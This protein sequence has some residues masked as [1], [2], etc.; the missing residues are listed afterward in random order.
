VISQ[1]ITVTPR[2]Q[3]LVNAGDGPC[4]VFNNDLLN[5]IYVG[6]DIGITATQPNVAQIAPLAYVAFD[7]RD[8]KWFCTGTG[9]TAQASVMPG[10]LTTSASPA[11]IA[12]QIA[13]SGVPLLPQ[14]TLLGSIDSLLTVVPGNTTLY[15]GPVPGISYAISID[16]LNNG[17]PT[18]PFMK[19]SLIWKNGP[20]G[21]TL[22]IQQW[23]ILTTNVS[24][25]SS[26]TLVVGRGPT[27][28]AQLTVIVDNYDV[29]N[30]TLDFGLWSSSRIITRHDFRSI[31]NNISGSYTY[32]PASIGLPAWPTPVSANGINLLGTAPNLSIGAASSL[33]RINGLYAG[34]AQLNVS[35]TS[36]AVYTILVTLFAADPD[37]T[38]GSPSQWTQVYAGQFAGGAGITGFLDALNLTLPR[39]P[40]L[41]WL[42]NQ[43]TAGFTGKYSLVSQEFAS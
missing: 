22:A 31:S 17:A 14:D 32:D 43:G 9:L 30:I 25:A 18:T 12:E 6:E 42:Q 15:S 35:G 37:L 10:A 28:S 21:S 2:A 11:L 41:L 33:A 36:L 40:T 5:T 4:L 26:N 39:A 24:P 19:L 3:V 8:T 29:N 13:L 27:M 1:T 38:G 23:I 7:G 34:Q 20:G 16:A